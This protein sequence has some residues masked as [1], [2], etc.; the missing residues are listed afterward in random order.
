MKYA[1]LKHQLST[2][3]ASPEQRPDYADAK[4]P[5]IWETIRRADD[6][7]QATGWEPPPSDC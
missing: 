4:A 6:W 3:F 2:D 7:A 1:I 5:F